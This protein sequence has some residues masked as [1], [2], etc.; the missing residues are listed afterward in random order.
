[1]QNEI[2]WHYI[3]R[4]A[5][6]NEKNANEIRNLKEAIKNSNKKIRKNMNPNGMKTGEYLNRAINQYTM[7]R[8]TP[9]LKLVL[10][11]HMYSR[12]H[13]KIEYMKKLAT[14]YPQLNN[15]PMRRFIAKHQR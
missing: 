10:L 2:T 15:K 12:L 13:H 14:N 5:L 9:R 6:R 4:R 11:Q 7:H 3:I 8:M 1:M